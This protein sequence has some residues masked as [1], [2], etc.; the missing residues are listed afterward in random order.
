[1]KNVKIKVPEFFIDWKDRKKYNIYKTRIVKTTEGKYR[2]D[3][4]YKIW[5]GFRDVWVILTESGYNSM[6]EFYKLKEAQNVQKEW[7]D[8]YEKIAVAAKAANTIIEEDVV[9]TIDSHPE[10][11]V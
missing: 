8:Y 7:I 5:F 2:T 10:H 11:F 6:K 4:C 3:G 9:K 1:M